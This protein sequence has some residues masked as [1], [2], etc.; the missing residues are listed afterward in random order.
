MS[1]ILGIPEKFGDFFFF[2]Q[3]DSQALIRFTEAAIVDD[4]YATT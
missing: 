4:G 1:R 2:G 3:K